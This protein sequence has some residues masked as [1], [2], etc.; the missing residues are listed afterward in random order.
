MTG[1]AH[2]MPAEWQPHDAAWLAW[3]SHPDEWPGELDGVRREHAALC[4]AILDVDPASGA[5]RGERVR[6]MVLAGES[7]ASARA[8]LAGLPVE[9]EHIPFGDIWLRDTGPIWVEGPAGLEA[10]CFRWNGWG[11]K[12]HFEHDDEVGARIAALTATP[13]RPFDLILEG[14]AIEVDGEGTMLTTRQCLLNPNRNPGLD[15][16]AIEAVLRD[17]FGTPRVLWLDQGLI[18]DHTDGHI[19]TVARFTRP[20]QV[21]CMAPCGPDDP[22]RDTLRA[23]ARDLAAMTDAVGRR[24]EV[25]TL[26]SPGAITNRAGELVAASYVNYYLGNTT[27]VVPTYGVPQ[28]EVAV[29]TLGRLFPGRRAIAVSARSLI[30]GGGGFHCVTQQQPRPAR[31]AA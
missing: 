29:A 19:D 20:G 3:P 24:L 10:A 9:L 12:Y 14:G 5:R 23:I 27:V 11:G 31:R 4:A 28:D 16:A 26:P 25:V 17:A 13:A 30:T 18:N 1:Q 8:A 7:E 15:Q 6:L 22:N 2:R 21:V